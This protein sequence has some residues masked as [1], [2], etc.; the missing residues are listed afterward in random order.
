[1][2]KFVNTKIPKATLRRVDHKHF[3]ETPKGS[4]YPS[5]TTMLKATEPEEKS[6]GLAAFNEKPEA[7]YIMIQAMLIGNQTHKLIENY[8]QDIA[9]PRD[10]Y[11]LLSIAHF[12]NL[13]GF[14]D[15]KV[16]NIRGVELKMW[17]DKLKLGGMSDCIAEYD[18]VLSIIDYKTKRSNVREEWLT[19]YFI[20]ATAY[21]IM[22]EELTGVPVPQAVILVSSEKNQQEEFIVPTANYIAAL[23]ERNMRYKLDISKLK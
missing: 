20:Q 16:N 1:M 9:S 14:I 21:S 10:A 23:T 15:G 19:D 5:V 22:F 4:L 8:L 13:K 12:Q 3:Y 2:F 6:E 7:N 11:R 17:S 18:G